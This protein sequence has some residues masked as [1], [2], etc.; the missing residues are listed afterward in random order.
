MN[1]NYDLTVIS[2]ENVPLAP[3]IQTGG[4]I[5]T[6]IA[7]VLIAVLLFVG[8]LYMKKCNQYKKRL[9]E[10]LTEAHADATNM[11][12]SSW[13]IRKLQIQVE[14]MENRVVKEICKTP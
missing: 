2:D 12:I 3:G 10:L 11:K 14:D 4:S 1:V 8:I 13:N 5:G 9:Q 7:V 6:A